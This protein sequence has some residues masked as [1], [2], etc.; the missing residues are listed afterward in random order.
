MKLVCPHCGAA[1]G[2][3]AWEADASIRQCLRL[4]SEMPREM[5]TRAI[6]YL[7][8]FR[9]AGGRG[10]SWPRALRLLTALDA[11][12]KTSDLSWKRRPA[13]PVSP[14]I[15]G[16]ALER[17]VSQPPRDLPLDGH[18]YLTAIAYGLAD[19]ADR[20]AERA[21]VRAER[22]GTRR[23]GGRQGDGQPREDGQPRG[24]AP[25]GG[26]VLTPEQVRAQVAEIRAK[27]GKRLY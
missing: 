18:G 11:L 2:A 23:C 20:G 15:W 26:G 1:A 14:R 8:L 17:I 9:P 16:A 4:V 27:I 19:E 21:Q 12:G 22:D 24:A 13:R 7:A 3:D 10:L 25:T 6:A 5:S